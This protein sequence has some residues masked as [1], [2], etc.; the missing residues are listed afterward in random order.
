[1]A[2]PP[3]QSIGNSTTQATAI[4]GLTTSEA[5]E[6]LAQFGPNN[7]ARARRS[8][9]LLEL[10]SLFL[11]PLVIIL[12]VASGISAALGQKTDAIIIFAIVIMSIAIDFVQT[13]RSQQTIQALREKVTPTA[14]VLR[15][16]VWGE[17]N[18]IE[19]VPG[20]IVRQGAGDLV[21]GDGQLLEARDL[22]LQEAALTGESMPEEKSAL[23][24]AT[25]ESGDSISAN[26][27][28]LGTSVVSGTGTARILA[29]GPNTAIGAIAERLVQ[30]PEKTEFERELQQFGHLILSAVFFLVLFILVVRVALHK[31]P[32][33]SF[34]FAVALAVGLTPEF[35]PMI[36]SVTLARGAAR[37]ARQNVVVK[38]LPAIQNFGSIDVFCSD[39]T[40]TLTA[41]KMTLNSSVD[42]LG[43]QTERAISLAYLNS[44]FET[45]IR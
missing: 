41:G 40:G 42:A 45:G 11:N 3:N 25:N 16:G 39:K 10:L 1:M 19:I 22:F 27:V 7:P 36:T 37:M 12:L 18:R 28:F 32:F 13:Y 14:T 8:A 6:R 26:K 44:K 33:E 29:T 31:D 17:I 30:R 23:A 43:E 21:P 4:T 38:H 24:G 34:L 9:A 5:R 35:L 15:D 20:D 2:T